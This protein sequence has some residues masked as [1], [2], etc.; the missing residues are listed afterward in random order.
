MF[1]DLDVDPSLYLVAKCT[2]L[3]GWAYLLLLLADLTTLEETW[4]LIILLPLSYPIECWGWWVERRCACD[5]SDEASESA[6]GRLLRPQ[7]REGTH[8]EEN[9]A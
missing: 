2:R 9:A 3:I 6:G 7:F 4:N 5:V 8:G 1:G